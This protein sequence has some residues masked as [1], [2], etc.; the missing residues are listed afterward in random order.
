MAIQMVHAPV[1]KILAS[2]VSSKMTVEGK[3]EPRISQDEFRWGGERVSKG[4]M[5]ELK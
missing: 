3:M 1:A 5:E 2:T 4:N